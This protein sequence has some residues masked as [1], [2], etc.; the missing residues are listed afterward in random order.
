MLSNGLASLIQLQADINEAEL[1]MMV[2]W[3]IIKGI[4]FLDFWHL[5]IWIILGNEAE[6]KQ[7][8]DKV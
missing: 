5:L 7:I 1:Y 4:V 2:D 6:S 8:K 3:S